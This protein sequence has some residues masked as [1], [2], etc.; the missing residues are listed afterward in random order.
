MDLVDLQISCIHCIWAIILK[1]TNQSYTA[2]LP[3]ISKE[4][5]SLTSLCVRENLPPTLIAEM[6]LRCSQG[7]PDAVHLCMEFPN[8][9]KYVSFFSNNYP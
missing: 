6:V 1:S 7:K 5:G 9:E 2:Q 3:L 8:T 4:T